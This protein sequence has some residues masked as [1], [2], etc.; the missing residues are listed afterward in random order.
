MTLNGKAAAVN[1]GSQQMGPRQ[2]H[3]GMHRMPRRALAHGTGALESHVPN[4][5]QVGQKFS[6]IK[7]MRHLLS[8]FRRETVFH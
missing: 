7:S 5:R 3:R 2:G 4:Q 8:F 1:D 6:T